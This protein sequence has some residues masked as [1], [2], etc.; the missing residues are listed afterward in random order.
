MDWRS[1]DEIDL[2][3]HV[4]TVHRWDI[5]WADLEPGVGSEQR[6]ESRP[7]IVISNDGFNAH[8]PLVTVVSFT[9]L[10]GKK[11]RVYD[12]EVL[13]PKGIVTPEYASIAMPQ[14]VRTIS[15]MRLLERIG[16]L[17]GEELREQIESRLLEHLG[18]AFEE[19]SP[20]V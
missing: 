11:R 8:F 14:Q 3:A 13:L 17:E 4:G 16:A 15:K 19:D 7:V 2:M 6:G 12:F 9:K 20:D 5:F 1:V 10:E 18:I